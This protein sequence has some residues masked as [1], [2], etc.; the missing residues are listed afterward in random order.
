MTK[1]LRIRHGPFGRVAV[2]EMDRR[3]VVHAHPHAHLLFKVAGADGGFGL[4]DRLLP[5]STEW[6]VAV[7]PWESHWYPKAPGGT[8]SLI[9]ALHI[10]PSW[11]GVR[12]D[13]FRGMQC[14]PCNG[15]RVNPRLRALVNT[16][17]AEMIHGGGEDRA[18]VEELL[19]TLADGVRQAPRATAGRKSECFTRVRPIDRRIRRSID[20]MHS[21]I[22]EHTGL[23]TLARSVGLSRQHFFDLFRRCTT[24]TPSVYWNMLRMERAVCELGS[25][26]RPIQDIAADLGFSAQSNFARFFRD[27]QGVSP[28]A[29]RNAVVTIDEPALDEPALPGAGRV[30]E[31]YARF[32]AGGV[33]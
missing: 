28:R 10:D 23:E 21:R 9:L 19:V 27:H 16:L 13:G 15:V 8:S 2:L 30:P 18:F 31:P 11:L 1:A 24:L 4:H 29:Y 33:Y 7:N 3:L 14:F 26:P 22:G 6:A 12:L 25:G 5:L 32:N 20:V 17:N